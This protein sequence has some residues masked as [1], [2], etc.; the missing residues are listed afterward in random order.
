MNQLRSDVSRPQQISLT[1]RI[2]KVGAVTIPAENDGTDDEYS[3]NSDVADHWRK[4][5]YQQAGSYD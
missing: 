3:V 2:K 4:Q 1:S 5:L